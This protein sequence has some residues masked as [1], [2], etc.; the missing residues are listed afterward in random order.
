MII[1]EFFRH[2]GLIEDDLGAGALRNT[3]LMLNKTYISK[4]FLAGKYVLQIF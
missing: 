1:A 4:I 3:L 2:A